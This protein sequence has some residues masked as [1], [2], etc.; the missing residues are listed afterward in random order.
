M[1]Q[2]LLVKD[3]IQVKF[4]ESGAFALWEFS[5]GHVD[6]KNGQGTILGRRW[7]ALVVVKSLE[8]ARTAIV[9]ALKELAQH[10]SSEG[11]MMHIALLS[12][13][14]ENNM[15]FVNVQYQI[16]WNLSVICVT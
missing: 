15:R 2:P 14:N 10:A 5:E 1:F 8:Y 6:T 12:A 11:N 13:E 16:Q 7:G 4:K 9:A 3:S